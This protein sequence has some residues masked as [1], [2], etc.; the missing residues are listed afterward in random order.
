MADDK[1]TYEQGM[2]DGVQLFGKVCTKMGNCANCPV[3]EVRGE[4]I[5]C[6]AFAKQFPKKMVS[7]LKSADDADYTYYDEFVTRFPNN[8]TDV[9]TLATNVCRQ[10]VFGGVANFVCDK[11]VEAD[12]SV[13][14]DCWLKH[15]EEDVAPDETVEEEF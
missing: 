10:F 15:Y 8:G 9:E 14:V 11:D 5:S 7:L 3:G 12:P 4:Q 2:E 1:K 6:P 13:C